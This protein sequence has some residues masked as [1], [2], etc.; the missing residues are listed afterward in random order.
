MNKK[1]HISEPEC[2]Y[3]WLSLASGRS[4][5]VGDSLFFF[6]Y[7]LLLEPT[8]GLVSFSQNLSSDAK[9]T[10]LFR[11]IEFPFCLLDEPKTNASGASATA[12]PSASLQGIYLGRLF[13]V[14]PKERCFFFVA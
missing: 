1:S 11:V 7:T 12:P 5:N 13:V 8:Q 2:C 9:S 10:L 14:W 4:D 6:P 3:P